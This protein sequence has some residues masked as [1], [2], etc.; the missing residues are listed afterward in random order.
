MARWRL[1][2]WGLGVV[3]FATPA[4][5]QTFNSS[6]APYL[7]PS[8]PGLPSSSPTYTVGP[9]DAG[10]SLMAPS[11]LQPSRPTDS[12]LTPRYELAPAR[13]P[14][15]SFPSGATRPSRGF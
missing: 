5:A 1:A 14:Q 9:R 11:V 6:P 12:V 10:S 15:Y 13:P 7:R 3:L 8:T 2:V 4:A